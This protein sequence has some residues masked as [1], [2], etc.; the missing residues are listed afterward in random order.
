M[1]PHR[2]ALRSLQVKLT[3]CSLNPL[4]P[5]GHYM[6]R[7]FNIQQFY[8]LP[9]WCIYTF[10]MDLKT[11]SDYFPIQNWLTDFYNQDLTL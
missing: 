7:P 1:A 8:V 10:C 9:T 5:T 3:V 6:Y 4:K 2:T 11:N